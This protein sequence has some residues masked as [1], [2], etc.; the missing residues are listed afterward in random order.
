MKKMRKIVLIIM[1]MIILVVGTMLIKTLIDFH[2]EEKIRNDKTK[3]IINKSEDIDKDITD[4]STETIIHGPMY[5]KIYNHLENL[6]YDGNENV[7]IYEEEGMFAYYFID[8][9]TDKKVM[10][11]VNKRD[12]LFGFMV[13]AKSDG[14]NSRIADKMVNDNYTPYDIVVQG[15]FVKA[16]SYS[17]E[18]AKNGNFLFNHEIIIKGYRLNLTFVLRENY[19]YVFFID[20]IEQ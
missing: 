3:G 16:I 5:I 12:R 7:D 11:S 15:Y 20:D 9:E 14:V 18:E 13:E 10:F 4:Q 19:Y 17:L 1:L 2:E 6:Y 8:E